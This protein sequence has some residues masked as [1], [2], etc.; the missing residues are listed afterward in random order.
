MCVV[1][2]LLLQLREHKLVVFQSDMLGVDQYPHSSPLGFQ[3]RPIVAPLLEAAG[4]TQMTTG[5]VSGP[6]GG[7][8]RPTARTL[9]PL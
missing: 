1:V 7:A 9:T 4:V 8:A 5:G 6:Q 3:Q 2:T